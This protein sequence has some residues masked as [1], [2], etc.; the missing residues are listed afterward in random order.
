MEYQERRRDFRFVVCLKGMLVRGSVPLLIENAAYRGVLIRTR[1]PLVVGQLGK[2]G[3][4][5][6]DD[7]DVVL[8]G[9]PVRMGAEGPGGLRALGLRLIGLEQRWEEFIRGLHTASGRGL[10]AAAPVS[11]SVVKA[12]VG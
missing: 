9:V 5:I 8:H 1:A 3:V 10:R 7:G 12:A 4:A 11:L 2:I 6:P